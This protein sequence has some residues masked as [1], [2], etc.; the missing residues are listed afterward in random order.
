MALRI[1]FMGSPEFALPS[2]EALIQSPHE[3]V[4]VV[5]GADKRRNRRGKPEP[6]PVKTLAQRHTI[7]VIEGEQPKSEEFEHELKAL[8]TIDLFVVVAFKI[9]PTNILAL[10]RIGSINL[11][12]SLLPKY[13]GAAPIHWA[14]IN[15]EKNTG[16]TVFL[17]NETVD[18]GNIIAQEA[19]EIGD[20]ETTGS[21]YERLMKKGAP[22]V[23]SA[24][25]DLEKGVVHL[26]EQDARLATPA[27]KL[28]PDQCEVD[29]NDSA[30]HIHNRIRGLNPFPG[31]WA[32]LDGERVKLHLSKRNPGS[33][34]QPGQLRFAA[35]HVLV[36]TGEGNL[37][38]LEL[39]IPGRKRISGK[40]FMRAYSGTKM[41]GR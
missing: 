18:T 6:T 24:I 1:V 41:F 21:V 35:E 2:L 28:F 9:L 26:K 11:H 30:E 38:L 25:S 4:A 15:G 29:F 17:L 8:S 23:L 37:A 19:I 16:N 13:R 22:L 10:P 36:G 12:A 34:L 27:P 5:S 39:Q 20:N 33:D 14:V 32:M 31:A 40:E 7:N 3:I